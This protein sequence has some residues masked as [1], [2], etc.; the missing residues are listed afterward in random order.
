[1]SARLV[2]QALS[3]QKK[4]EQAHFAANKAEILKARAKD[5]RDIRNNGDKERQV[6][7]AVYL[8]AWEEERKRAKRRRRSATAAAAAAPDD[9]AAAPALAPAPA[10]A[11][12]TV[13]LTVPA[14]ENTAL[15]LSLWGVIFDY[16]GS[17]KNTRD[18]V[19]N[20]SIAAGDMIKA[21]L[22]C[23]DFYAAAVLFGWP[24]VGASCARASDSVRAVAAAG[25][26]LDDIFH[27]PLAAKLPQLKALLRVMRLS[28]TG[29]KAVL[30]MRL[31]KV[32]VAPLAA[33]LC[34]CI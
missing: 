29:T 4:Q 27:R 30:I 24:A 33:E 15:P 31:M 14:K 32:R 20:D 10:P 28:V 16:I 12:A 8:A 5:F 13:V 7:A 25:C 34:C 22:V 6:K 11:P 23:S 18:Q 19:R 3:I 9:A 2:R 17:W 1:M 26:T 21:S